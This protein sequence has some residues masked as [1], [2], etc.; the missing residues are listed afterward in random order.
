MTKIWNSTLARIYLA[1]RATAHVSYRIGMGVLALYQGIV[2]IILNTGGSAP[3]GIIDSD[4]YGILQVVAALLLLFTSHKFRTTKLGNAAAAALA[5]IYIMLGVDVL[6]SGISITSGGS[7]I[8]MAALLI[9]F[10][11]FIGEE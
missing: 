2:R 8:I 4:H 7:A 6:I 11:L 9:F 1:N 5:A 10:E 3:V